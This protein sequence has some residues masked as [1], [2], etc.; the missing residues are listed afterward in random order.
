MNGLMVRGAAAAEAA[1]YGRRRARLGVGLH[2]DLAEW[3][4]QDGTWTALY[5]VVDSADASA[6]E[7]EVRRQLDAFIALMARPPTHLDSHQH[8][9]RD[10]PLCTIA[11]RL[12]A[13]LRIPLRHFSQVRY[14]GEFY[15]QSGKGD[16]VPEAITVESLI[17]VLRRLPAG[18]SELACHPGYAEDVETIY[19]SERAREVVT[20]CDAS[21]KRC[22][23][24]E[25]IALIDF[26]G[27]VSHDLA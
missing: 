10:E 15:G 12:A 5:Q 9:H 11:Q 7:K 16:P 23:F 17:A 27:M 14:C 2:L 21:V 25:Q 8:V 3:I 1:D 22:L 26:S 13:D 6:V 4:Y 18:I 19:R 20:L 24:E